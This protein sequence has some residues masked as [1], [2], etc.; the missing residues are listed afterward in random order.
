M[1]GW[2]AE[3]MG[4]RTGEGHTFMETLLRHR[5]KCLATHLAKHALEIPLPDLHTCTCMEHGTGRGA[6]MYAHTHTSCLHA[7]RMHTTIA[8]G[9]HPPWVIPLYALMQAEARLVYGDVAAS[10][11][12]LAIRETCLC[13][14]RLSSEP[15]PLGSPNC[16]GR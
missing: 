3:V 16:S 13:A 14:K 11:F 1:E 5:K 10:T 8:P 9:L 15:G 12:S 7:C 2:L 4:R 6:H